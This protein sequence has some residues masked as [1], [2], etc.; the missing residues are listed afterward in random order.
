VPEGHVDPAPESSQEVTRVVP[1][2]VV[3]LGLETLPQPADEFALLIRVQL[4]GIDR[5]P[6]AQQVGERNGGRIG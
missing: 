5:R 4:L 2:A 6:Q 1:D 3:V